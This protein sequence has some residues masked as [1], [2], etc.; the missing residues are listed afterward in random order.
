MP[1]PPTPALD[2]TVTVARRGVGI[3]YGGKTFH[4][5]ETFRCSGPHAEYMVKHGLAV[6]GDTLPVEPEPVTV[7][8]VTL[9]SQGPAPLPFSHDPASLAS[10]SLTELNA[11]IAEEDPDNEIT[12]QTT[13]ADAI[14]I[15]STNFS[16]E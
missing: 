12:A 16:A 3:S 11:L 7:M 15:L 9:G 13:Q 8:E 1:K 6:R 10:R 2:Q 14:S 5:G 4:P